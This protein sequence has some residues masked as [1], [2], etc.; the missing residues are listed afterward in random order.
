MILFPLMSTFVEQILFF[1]EVYF[2]IGVENHLARVASNKILHLFL[3]LSIVF[4]LE[5]KIFDA[6]L[7]FPKTFTGISKSTFITF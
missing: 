1:P 3:L 4:S 2:S 7:G 6:T 5:V